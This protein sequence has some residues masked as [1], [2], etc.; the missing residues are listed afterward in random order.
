MYALPPADKPAETL[1]MQ[2]ELNIKVA[3]NH[4]RSGAHLQG[5]AR[6]A[7]SHETL[8]EARAAFVGTSEA[9][10][11]HFTERLLREETRVCA[12]LAQGPS[13]AP[14]PPRKARRRRARPP[15]CSTGRSALQTWRS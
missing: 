2:G 12:N 8:R 13:R 7:A 15:F 14:T 4:Y 6:W 11:E 1:L 10:C 5:T 9:E 3:T